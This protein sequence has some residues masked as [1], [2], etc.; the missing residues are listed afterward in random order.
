MKRD[1]GMQDQSTGQ[2]EPAST[3]DYFKK[4]VE[5]VKLSRPAMAQVA[6]DP[7]AI[8]FGIA[9]TAIGGALAFIP[10]NSLAAV[11][12]GA[13]FS[14]FVLFLFAGLVHLFCGYSKGKQEFMGFVRIIGLSGIIDWAVI[15]PFAGLAV[16]VWSV[17]I[18]V[19]AAQKVYLLTRGKA[20]FTV[21]I[22]ALILLMISL[23]IFAGPLSFLYEIPGQ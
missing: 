12:V 6:G 1:E 4:A 2:F 17:V 16:T 19:V 5:I 22:S 7:N 14:V 3:L 23:M 11:L 8:K 10:G 15:I 21:L 9:V 18:S 20:T 13:L